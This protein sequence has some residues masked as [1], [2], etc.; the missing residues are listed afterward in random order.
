MREF[1]QPYWL[2]VLIGLDQF[3]NAIANGDPDETVSSRIGRAQ[4]DGR[5]KWWRKPLHYVIWRG[6]EKLDP[7]HCLRSIE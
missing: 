6:L 4:R 3:L 7:G 5:L 2:R 1:T